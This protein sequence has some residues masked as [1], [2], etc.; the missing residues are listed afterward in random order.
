M[1]LRIDAH[2]HFWQ[3]QPQ[4]YGWI[5]EEMARLKQDYLPLQLAPELAAQ[6][7]QGSVLVQA[8]QTLQETRWLLDVAERTPE[9][10]AV[11]GWIDLQQGDVA[12]Q[13][14]DFEPRTLLRGFRHL[15]QDEAD[16][17]QWMEQ[18]SVTSA[19]QQLQRKEY[20][21]DLLVTHQHLVEATAFAARHDEHQ[22]VLDHLGKPDLAAGA[23]HWAKQIAPLAALPH[24]SCKLSGLLTEPRPQGYA[25]DDLLPFVDAALEAFGS[26]RVLAGSDWPVCLLAGDYQDAWQLIQRAIASLSASEQVAISGGNACRIYRIEDVEV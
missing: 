11:V 2:Q 24:V 7:V 26:E 10:K 19:V 23:S 9:V 21:W 1:S 4:E 15:I 12:A 16:P 3:Y 14:A 13:L 8:R 22:I 25:I 20:V 6:S 18:A 5:G 17:A